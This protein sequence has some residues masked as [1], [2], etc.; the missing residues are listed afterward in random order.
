MRHVN[1]VIQS[2]I[3]TMKPKDGTVGYLLETGTANGPA[4]LSKVFDVH[5][6]NA[7]ASELTALIEALKRL[8]EPCR[9]TIYT[10]SVYIAGA[11]ENG[12]TDRWA[13][14]GW[15]TAKG[16]DVANKELWQELMRLLKEHEVSFDTENDIGYQSWLVTEINRKERTHV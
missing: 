14:S 13:A 5:G 7:N 12:W 10:D 16:K 4:T 2:G 8:R 1:I 9:L 11:V 6:Q 15:T 3:K